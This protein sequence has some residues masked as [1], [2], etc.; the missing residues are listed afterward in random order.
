MHL[1][2]GLI[3]CW[4]VVCSSGTA[5]NQDWPADS[6][7]QWGGPNRDHKSNATG[8]L[9]QWSKSG[10]ALA[11]QFSDAGA[12]YSSFSVFDGK[13]YTL[14]AKDGKNFAI[15]INI[16]DGS[17]AWRTELG[18]VPDEESYNHGWA[19]GPRSTPTIAGDRVIVLDDGGTLA[20]LD[21]S[22][23][24]VQWSRHLVEDFGGAIPKWGYAASPLVDKDCVVVCPGMTK[25][26]VAL[27]LASGDERL[28]STGFEE[29]AHYVSVVKHTVGGIP[30]YVTAAESGLV[31]FSA[32]NGSVLWTHN[33]SGN[34]T[35]TVTTPILNDN[36]VYHTSA[37]STGCVLV[38][39]TTNDGKLSARQVYKNLNQQNHHGGVVLI[40]EHL[41]GYRR[42]AGIVCQD[43]ASGEIAWSERLS[44][45]SSASIAFADG[46]LY[47]YGESS[48]TCYLVEPTPVKWI[49]HGRVT[50]PKQ[51]LLD[52]RQGKI[53][54]HPVIAEGKLFLRDMDLI[55]AFDIAEQ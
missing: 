52:R 2:Y 49:E 37:Y 5:Y 31:A 24:D 55:F 53:W 22:S 42:R 25:F 11:W 3:V 28:A 33:G 18:S 9:Q 15:C 6:W 10:P 43:F 26:L 40:D 27:D 8:L 47:V 30:T 35:A 4:I 1:R 38:E 20:C 48:G 45:D 44:G 21:R 17:E 34:A 29:R 51:T 46:R 54:A 32:E 41:Y 23:G 13:L 19:G 39:V 50:I 36:L 7:P 12:G 14:G 16:A